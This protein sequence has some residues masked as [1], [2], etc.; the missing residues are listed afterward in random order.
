MEKMIDAAVELR[1]RRI[2]HND[3][4]VA[5]IL[6][7]SVGAVSH[8]ELLMQGLESLYGESTFQWHK[9]K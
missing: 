7:V 1:Y 5:N 9:N 8:C 2:I 4:K 3:V 6:H